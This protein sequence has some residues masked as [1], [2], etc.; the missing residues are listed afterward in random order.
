MYVYPDII[1]ALRTK[2]GML[3]Q[4]NAISKAAVFSKDNQ[5]RLKTK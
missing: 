4:F 3:D 2:S 5:Q 1:G